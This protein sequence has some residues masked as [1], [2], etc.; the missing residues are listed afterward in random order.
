M[1]LWPSTSENSQTTRSTPGSSVNTVRKCAKSTCACQPG[2]V[3]NRTSKPAG[4]LGRTSRRKS[5]T[6]V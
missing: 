4:A 5:F 6:M 3:S 2:G 1:R